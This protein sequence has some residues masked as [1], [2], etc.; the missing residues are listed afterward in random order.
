MRQELGR[1]SFI[2][3]PKPWRSKQSSLQRLSGSPTPRFA[4]TTPT[5]PPHTEVQSDHVSPPETAT[6]AEGEIIPASFD[7]VM[8]SV[9]PPVYEHLGFLKELGLDYGWGTTAF[10]QTVLEHVHIY[11]GTPWWASI[12]ITVVLIRASLFKFFVD[13]AD[14]NARRQIIKPLEEP[15]TERMK[16]AQAEKNRMALQEIWR[17]RSALHRSAGII[18]WKSFL[19]FLQLPLGFGIFRLMRG[20]AYLP[21]PGLDTG[22]FLWVHDLT[23]SDPYYILPLIASWAYYYAFKVP[24]IAVDK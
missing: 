9:S 16:V 19:P 4:S 1:N 18:W 14:S 11:L 5:S 15:L 3:P 24:S 2:R 6:P 10:V 20:M 17:E 22:G 21:V 7:E 12:G 13:A 8:G 23:V